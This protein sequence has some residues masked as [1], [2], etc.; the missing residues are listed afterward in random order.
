MIKYLYRE[1]LLSIYNEIKKRALLTVELA[2]IY[3]IQEF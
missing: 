2:L 3:L 1:C